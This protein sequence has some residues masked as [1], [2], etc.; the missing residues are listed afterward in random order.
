MVQSKPADPPAFPD[1]LDVQEITDTE[2]SL[3]EVIDHPFRYQS[4]LAGLITVPVG[5]Q[6]DF[7]SVPRIPFIFDELGEDANKPSVVHDWLYYSA[8]F[9]KEISDKILLEAMG[10]IG[11]SAFRKYPIYWGVVI[12]GKAAW[13]LHRKLGNKASDYLQ[14]KP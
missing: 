2:D 3:W 10:A 11:M 1:S 14:I 9:T 4:S 5:F 12:G 13:D 6:T 8:L 7:A